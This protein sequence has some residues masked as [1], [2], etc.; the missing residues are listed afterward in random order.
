MEIVESTYIDGFANYF[1]RSCFKI[2]LLCFAG[3]WYKA[4]C[5]EMFC[6]TEKEIK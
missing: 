2:Q 6:V 4:Q 3:C 5:P 1:E